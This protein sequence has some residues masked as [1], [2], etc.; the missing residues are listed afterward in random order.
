MIDTV[1]GFFDRYQQ[2]A[3]ND[4]KLKDLVDKSIEV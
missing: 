4:N 3:D 1:E 2:L